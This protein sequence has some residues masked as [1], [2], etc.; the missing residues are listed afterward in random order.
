MVFSS[1]AVE[2][3]YDY[4]EVTYYRP[5]PDYQFDDDSSVGVNGSLSVQR[6]FGFAHYSDAEIRV[7]GDGGG[8][9]LG[10]WR[11][12]GLGAYLPLTER[13]HLVAAV[14]AQ[15]AD[16]DGDAEQ[17]W[18]LHAGARGALGNRWWWSLEAGYLDLELSDH[19]LNAELGFRPH[20]RLGVLFRIRDYAEWDFTAYELGVRLSGWD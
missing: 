8:R 11:E 3:D 13:L 20:D 1:A 10:Q 9:M 18:R 5:N 17:G 4:L 12:L 16:I 15:Q 6:M 14:S 7:G 2:P 19:P